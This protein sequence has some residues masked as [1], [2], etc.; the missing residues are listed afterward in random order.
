MIS[1]SAFFLGK[2]SKALK[3]KALPALHQS[4]QQSYPQK[5]G[6]S[7]KHVFNQALTAY[8]NN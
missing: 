7:Q 1:N 4:Y 8:F 3:N 6:M 2:A 5:L